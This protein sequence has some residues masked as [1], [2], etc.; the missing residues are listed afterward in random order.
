MK[1]IYK[2]INESYKT[3]N[4]YNEM[5]LM[6]KTILEAKISGLIIICLIILYCLMA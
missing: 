3:I 1:K 5:E 4:E 2:I 6:A